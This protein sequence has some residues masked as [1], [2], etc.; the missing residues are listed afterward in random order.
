MLLIQCP[1]CA[2][3]L[4]APVSTVD[5]Y[6]ATALVDRRC[7]ECGHEDRV[8]TT[9]IAAAVWERHEAL[10][11]ASLRGLAEALAD[12]LPVELSELTAI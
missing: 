10:L 5:L 8:V 7:P 6:C 9:A 2:S 1:R 12:G 11:A 3:R 4:V